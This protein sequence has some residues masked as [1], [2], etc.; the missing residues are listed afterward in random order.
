MSNSNN[1][2]NSNP[3]SN[4]KPTWTNKSFFSQGTYTLRVISMRCFITKMDGTP[5]DIPSLGLILGSTD[6][7]DR[8]QVKI[9]LICPKS[10]EAQERFLKKIGVVLQALEMGAED[11]YLCG[12]EENPL[13]IESP[14]LKDRSNPNCPVGKEITV[15]HARS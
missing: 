7:N 1:N 10:A 15:Q 9:G 2:S 12:D 6:K 14:V 4:I 5:H 3:F 13:G 8:R 11:F